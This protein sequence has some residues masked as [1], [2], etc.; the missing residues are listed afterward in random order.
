MKGP[1]GIDVDFKR[2]VGEMGVQGA[3]ETV[4]QEQRKL[5]GGTPAA[6]HDL[7]TNSAHSLLM[8]LCFYAAQVSDVVARNT[9]SSLNPFTASVS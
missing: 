4:S 1:V 9:N 8:Y 2:D 6:N 3:A 7:H 5:I